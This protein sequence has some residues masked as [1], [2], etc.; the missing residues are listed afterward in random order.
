M[1]VV[2][3]LLAAARAP[4]FDGARCRENPRHWDVDANL[5]QRERAAESCL[6]K[7]PELDRCA[8]WLAGLQPD[9][10]PS[11]TVAGRFLQPGPMRSAAPRPDRSRP[12]R[13]S[14]EFE[15]AV[16]WLQCHLAGRGPTLSADVKRDAYADGINRHALAQAR[17]ALDV[18]VEH[19]G[20]ATFWTL[21]AR[22][23]DN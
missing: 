4:Y 6:T 15:R 18:L 9:A 5:I 14:V 23:R 16:D 7:C 3:L 13:Q 12:G 2:D 20:K 19:C 1:T 8:R 21:S 22:R 10:R 11:G 17:L